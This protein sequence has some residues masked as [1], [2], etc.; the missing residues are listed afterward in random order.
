MKLDNKGFTV[1]ELIL[2]FVLVMFLAMS[3]F[4][5]VNNYKNREQKEAVKRDLLALQNTLTQDIYEDT[6][7]RKVDYIE[8]CKDE[9][10]NN[11][12]QCI[13]INF[14]DNTAKQLKIEKVNKP[15][16]ED[17]TTFE[18]E[19][20]NILYGGVKYD[21]PDP[22]FA[23]VVSDYILTSTIEDD[24]LEY[25]VIYHIKIRIE[26]QDLEDEYVVD[27]VTTGVK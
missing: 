8:Y 11:I 16:T 4:A 5:L 13:N 9:S 7:E 21:N 6:T 27:V 24:N 12:T 25:G 22:K 15:V 2:S 19:T 17:G 18:F 26:H 14:L 3:M 23:K 20:F 1:I 10:G